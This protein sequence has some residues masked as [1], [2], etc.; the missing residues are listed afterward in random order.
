MKSP[1]ASLLWRSLKV[2]QVFGANTDVGK[3]IF[4]TFLARSAK[5][6]W[7]NEN[8]TF[9]K[10]VSTGPADEADHRCESLHLQLCVPLQ[11]Q[12]S[13]PNGDRCKQELHD[14]EHR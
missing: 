10:P 4:T 9:L 12:E 1:L 13:F 14:K 8:V 5:A 7:K 2:C 3:T 6:Q 11:F